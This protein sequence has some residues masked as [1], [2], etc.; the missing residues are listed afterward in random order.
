MRQAVMR[1]FDALKRFRDSRRPKP[2]DEWFRV[3]FDEDEIRGVAEPPGGDSFEFVLPWT[4]IEKIVF[5]AEDLYFSDWI[6]L[7]SRETSTSID[8]PIEA[9]GAS[10]LWG[11]ILRRGLFDRDLAGEA[12]RSLGGRF[13]WPPPESS[14]AA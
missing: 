9:D 13:E 5:L 8:I 11:E 7:F 14:P 1:I 6:C 10:D 4:D 2:F 3:T 12:I